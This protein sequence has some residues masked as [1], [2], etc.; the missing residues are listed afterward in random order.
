MKINGGDMDVSDTIK[1]MANL[2]GEQEGIDEGKIKIT[3]ST[4][5]CRTAFQS[6]H[7]FYFIMDKGKIVFETLTPDSLDPICY[8]SNST[9]RYRKLVCY[10]NLSVIVIALPIGVTSSTPHFVQSSLSICELF[11]GYVKLDI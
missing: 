5:W 8:S 6:N 11:V 7:A 10:S 1:F 2:N 9:I 4:L 3:K